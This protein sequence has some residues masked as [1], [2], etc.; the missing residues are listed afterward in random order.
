MVYLTEYSRGHVVNAVH[1]TENIEDWVN[2]APNSRDRE[3]RQAVHTILQAICRQN[4]LRFRVVL[5]GGILL[6]IRYKSGRY[7][8]DIDLSSESP[9]NDGDKELTRQ[10]FDEGL[11]DAQEMLSY[12]LAC[13]VQSIQ[14]DPKNVEKPTNPSM[15]IKIGYA[16]QGT[17]KHKRL[18]AGQSP[19]VISVDYSLNEPVPNPETIEIS[20]GEGLLAY[21]LIDLVAEKIRSLLQQEVR[22]R[23]RRQDIFDLHMIFTNLSDFD[24]EDKQKILH[25][26]MRKSRARG[27]E[28]DID[29]LNQGEIR[30]RAEQDYL[31]LADEIEEDLPNFDE[32]YQ[33]ISD[34]YMSLPW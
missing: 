7:T 28:P 29:S 23:F 31:T 12:G 32:A 10:E 25:S 27:L 22:N 6:A 8:K 21:S 1:E 20:P 19:S 2:S 11:L 34:F 26:L 13:K 30:R 15:K 14:V 4:G 24:E 9:L 3:F 5:K 33:I 17:T 16:Y 18:I